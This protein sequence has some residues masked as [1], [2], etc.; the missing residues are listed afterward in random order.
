MTL[1]T[2]EQ[3]IRREKA[4]SNICTNQGLCA[5]IAAIYLSALG[6][7]GLRDV[8]EQNLRK[9][10]YLKRLLG[11]RLVFS[12]PT[13][14]EFVVRCPQKP[15]ELN[16]RLLGEGIIGGLPLGRFFGDRTDQMLVCVTEQTTRSQM[17]DFARVFSR[18]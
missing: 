14:N 16:R 2:R 10:H 17:D 4:T 11:D 3:H 6:R 9:A 7:K 18:A 12:G 15:E 5:L 8:A 13:F 1:S